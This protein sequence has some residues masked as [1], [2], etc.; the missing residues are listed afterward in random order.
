[1]ALGDERSLYGNTRVSGYEASVYEPLLAAGRYTEIPSNQQ[2]LYDEDVSG[3]PLYLGTAP[4]GLAQGTD[5]WMINK[6]TFS[7]INPKIIKGTAF[8][9]W[10]ARAGYTYT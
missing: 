8:G 4:M 6:F 9:N 5:G 1:M 3:K 2:L 10:T 7:D